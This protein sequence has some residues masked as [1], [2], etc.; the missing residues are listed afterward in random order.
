MNE[1]L[2]QAFDREPGKK[3]VNHQL[4]REG[5]IP[6]VLYGKRVFTKPVYL[7]L[8]DL[9]NMLRGH[10]N[11]RY[12]KLQI[13]DDVFPVMVS[14]IQ[15][16]PVTGNILHVDLHQIEMNEKIL[17][18]VPIHL[19]GESRGVLEG[20][21]LQRQRNELDIRCTPDRIPEDVS[22]DI[23]HMDIGDTLKVKDLDVPKGIEVQNDQEELILSILAPKRLNQDAQLEAPKEEPVVVGA[24]DGPG[25]DAA[26]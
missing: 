14:E 22:V 25:I 7:P 9:T 15:R 26:T 12:F 13:K 18:T 20:G 8:K 1:S 17:T 10:G 2:L 3:S 21:I 19:V 6:G 24:E 4:R 23:R 5:N 11:S 16:S